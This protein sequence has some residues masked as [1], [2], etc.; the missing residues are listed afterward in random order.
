[1]SYQILLAST[2]Y[3]HEALVLLLLVSPVQ[4]HLKWN[5]WCATLK[6]LFPLY[7][8]TLFLKAVLPSC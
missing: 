6:T 7:Q 4:A 5:V 2:F 3:K 8:N 1:M